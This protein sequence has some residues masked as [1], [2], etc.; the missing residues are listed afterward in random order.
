MFFNLCSLH[1]AHAWKRDRGRV[2]NRMDVDLLVQQLGL[3]FPQ[4]EQQTLRN[5]VHERLLLMPD[6]LDAAVVLD[7]CINWMLDHPEGREDDVMEENQVDVQVI[8]ARASSQ[9]TAEVEGAKVV[10]AA[11][12]VSCVSRMP[13]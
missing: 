11:E 4:H 12:W 7:A 9:L 6:E 3:V 2:K 1:N 13:V 5:C 10:A 8:D